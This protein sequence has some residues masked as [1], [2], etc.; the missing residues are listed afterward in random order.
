MHYFLFVVHFVM[1]LAL[2][3]LHF[4][5]V[6]TSQVLFCFII[7]VLSMI[8]W[9]IYQCNLM[10]FIVRPGEVKYYVKGKVP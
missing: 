10:C 7:M 9:S 8:L 6:L 4:C 3:D 1:R 2:L 5:E